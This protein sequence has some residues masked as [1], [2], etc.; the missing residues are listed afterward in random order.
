MRD[1]KGITMVAL[2]ITIILLIILAGISFHLIVGNNGLIG[3]AKQVAVNVTNSQQQESQLINSV[4]HKMLSIVQTGET[5][6]INTAPKI[7][8]VEVLKAIDRLTMK[9]KAED[10]EDAVLVYKVYV[11]QRDQDTY[12]EK[13][14]ITEEVTQTISIEVAGLTM[15]TEY[16]YKIEVM[17][18][19]GVKTEQIG[20][21]KTLCSGTTLYC[22]SA[23]PAIVCSTFDRYC[24]GDYCNGP[25][26]LCLHNYSSS[27][28]VRVYSI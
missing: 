4:Y 5:E 23:I 21:S 15:Y 8:S 1:K 12:I 13:G 24:N 11:K 2:M 14:S 17:D 6:E 28:P 10:N 18:P 22:S 27:C 20:V 19:K 25:F 26:D 9:V 3:K 7:A 16:D